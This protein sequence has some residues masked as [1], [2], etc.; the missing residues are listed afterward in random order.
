MNIIESGDGGRKETHTL[1][2]VS[3]GSD[4]RP[5]DLAQ[6]LPQ[7]VNVEVFVVSSRRRRQLRCATDFNR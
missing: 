1:V 5:V 4:R 3:R 6:I 2:D 7:G